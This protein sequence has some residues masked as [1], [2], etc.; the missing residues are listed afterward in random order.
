M[1]LTGFKNKILT[2]RAQMKRGRAEF[3]HSFVR[4]NTLAAFVKWSS[5]LNEK[6]NSVVDAQPWICFEA[7]TYLDKVLTK[8]FVVFEY[9]SGGSTLYFAGKCKKVISVE[10][11]P[12]WYKILK[13][14][15][16]KEIK[17]VEYH[18]ILPEKTDNFE[19]KSISNP[20]DFVSD[21]SHYA[22]MNFEKYVKQ[23]NGCEDS[24]LDLVVV[25]GRAR[26]SC[27][28]AA[29]KKIKMGG[30]L[31]CDNSERTYYFAENTET[32]QKFEKVFEE[33]GPVPYSESF[34]QT[35]IFKRIQ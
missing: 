23:I 33:F 31:L 25:D 34:S 32:L 13:P 4:S 26:T 28:Y 3:R 10:H 21:D 24:S 17:N 2:F 6:R 30:Y 7:K 29:S 16:D 22:G 8:E 19:H 18:C 15:F 9:G 14:K 35:T 27:I 5:S 20:M 12:E 11:E 1:N